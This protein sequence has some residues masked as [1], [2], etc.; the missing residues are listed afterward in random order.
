MPIRNLLN[1][2]SES[3]Y[4]ALS[5]AEFDT[6]KEFTSANPQYKSLFNKVSESGFGALSDAEFEG[7][8]KIPEA[9]PAVDKTKGYP[10]ATPQQGQDLLSRVRYA[11]YSRLSPDEKAL[12]DRQYSYSQAGR[13][14]MTL[15][16]VRDYADANANPDLAPQPNLWDV[17]KS[18]PGNVYQG[19]RDILAKEFGGPVS[20]YL[21]GFDK[22]KG[23]PDPTSPTGER[24]V[25][26]IEGS[27]Y[28]ERVGADYPA[29]VERGKMGIGLAGTMSDPL[30]LTMMIP[31]VGEARMAG[32]ISKIPK[33]G[34]T[35]SEIRYAPAIGSA[36]AN[37]LINAGVAGAGA[38]ID[39]LRGSASDVTGSTE[40]AGLSP[41]KQ[42]AIAGTIGGGLSLFGKGAQE[43]AT[44]IYP[45]SNEIVAN[46][47]KH[48]GN[49]A[50]TIGLIRQGMEEV[51]FPYTQR[52]YGNMYQSQKHAAGEMMGEA[53]RSIPEYRAPT[54]EATAAPVQD[55]GSVPADI[56]AD[57]IALR[58]ALTR[59]F[60]APAEPRL[61]TDAELTLQNQKL[62]PR[63][64]DP[65]D[66][67]ERVL[68]YVKEMQM[69]DMQGNS[70]VSIDPN[71]VDKQIEKRGKALYTSLTRQKPKH[72]DLPTVG[73]D[74]PQA[75]QDLLGATTGSIDIKDLSK[76][77]NLFK[78]QFK[79]RSKEKEVAR[80]YVN[81]LFHQATVQRMKEEP[82]YAASLAA[83]GA[84]KKFAQAANLAMY[85]DQGVPLAAGLTR[86]HPLLNTFMGPTIIY[87]G[88][89]LLQRPGVANWLTR[90]LGLTGTLRDMSRADTAQ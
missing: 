11:G 24:A 79:A 84:E 43:V 28:G 60:G 72:G 14:G 17:A 34:R 8:K 88:G 35:I 63:S 41:L 36:V 33:V 29:E 56:A 90:G 3:G 62:Y 70:P 89:Q 64:I 19:T 82:E 42:A 5:D 44:N 78:T 47:L 6:L 81:D 57:P 85:T 32:L 75:E 76:Q 38:Y 30:N 20:A 50:E 21:S 83:S 22:Y 12:F 61:L 46:A 66:D 10:Y 80:D 9:M 69:K 4:G 31:A 52:S 55:L 23:V 1:K 37:G 40:S 27:T 54:G 77:R 26:R 65:K 74:M 15:Q 71:L 39:P 48:G 7:L 86:A 16:Q 59:G 67:Y 18:I 25:P 2:V 51:P 49:E 13:R 68:G 58:G 73:T 45:R 53:E 87:K